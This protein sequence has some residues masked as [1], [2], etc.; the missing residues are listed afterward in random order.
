M[1][2]LIKQEIELHQYKT[3]Q[4]KID[5]ERLIHPDFTEV[6]KSGNSYDFASTTQ[7]MEVEKP[8]NARVHSQNYE[9]V[10]LGPSVQLL[11]YESAL[12]SESGEVSDFAK[13]CSIWTFTGTCW[14][15]RY[16]QGTPCAP[17]EL[18]TQPGQLQTKI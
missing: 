17:F 12:I 16:H 15:L 2:I 8:S 7:M 6:G 18:K 3:R 9:C 4:N 10:Q 1:D 13:R 14:Q 11:K 5:I